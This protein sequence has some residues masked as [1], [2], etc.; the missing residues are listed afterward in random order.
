MPKTFPALQ[1]ILDSWS[2]SYG[3]PD[4]SAAGFVR[5]LRGT[6]LD[7]LDLLQKLPDLELLTAFL[8]YVLVEAP[9]RGLN[10]LEMEDTEKAMRLLIAGLHPVRPEETAWIQPVPALDKQAQA[11]WVAS[12]GRGDKTPVR[13]WLRQVDLEVRMDPTCPKGRLVPEKSQML[14]NPSLP[15]AELPLVVLHEARHWSQYRTFLGLK[16]GDPRRELLSVMFDLAKAVNQL[17]LLGP[18]HPTV[19]KLYEMNVLEQDARTASYEQLR[20]LSQ[21][22]AKPA[23]EI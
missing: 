6:P 15:P 4:V 3:L 5:E 16:E 11:T 22:P 14:L 17:R 18:K 23:P 13:D 9:K 10:P 8:T 20:A 21:A 2:A 19:G 1:K 7:K 12:W